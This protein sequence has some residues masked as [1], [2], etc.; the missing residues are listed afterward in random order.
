MTCEPTQLDC[1]IQ[2]SLLPDTRVTFT[3]DGVAIDLSGYTGWQVKG[4]PDGTTT[5]V[6]TKTTGITAVGDEVVIAW[7][8]ADLG[9]CW[10]GDWEL[11]LTG[12][13]GA[14]PRKAVLLLTIDPKAS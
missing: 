13:L 11:E 5:S 3:D 1:R 14:K 10:P 7:A 2:G 4:T 6:W 9:A 8:D 12:L